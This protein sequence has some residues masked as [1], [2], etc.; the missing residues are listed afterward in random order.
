MQPQFFEVNGVVIN[1][2]H[3]VQIDFRTPDH[4]VMTLSTGA[5][6]ELHGQDAHDLRRFFMPQPAQ[7]H[8]ETD[9]TAAAG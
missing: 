2:S 9:G 1:A 7:P 4:V 3:V 5:T 6:R 8:G